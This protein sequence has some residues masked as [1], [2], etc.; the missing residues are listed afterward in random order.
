MAEMITVIGRGHSGTRVVS[1]TLSASGVYMG[2]PLNASGDLVPPDDMY[3]ACRVI[4]RHVVHRGGLD[5]DFAKLHT[6]PIDPAF[7]RLIE[8]Y[9]ASVL[10]GAGPLKGWKIPE[11]TLALPWIVRL[12]PEAHYIFWVRNPRDCILGPHVTPLP[13]ATGLQHEAR[14]GGA[15]IVLRVRRRDLARE[16]ASCHAVAWAVPDLAERL[17]EDV[18]LVLGRV[19]PTAADGHLPVPVD[20][21]GAPRPT[22]VHQFTPVEVGDVRGTV[23]ELAVWLEHISRV[24][25]QP[26]AQVLDGLLQACFGGQAQRLLVGPST[27]PPR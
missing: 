10:A 18:A 25:G 21:A 4:G 9:L 19:E 27:N 26:V 20:H 11:T 7:T 22:A 13:P 6:M 5:W 15:G 3:E 12:F 2:E 17:L 1:H 24:F 8:S 14:A 16:G 23:D